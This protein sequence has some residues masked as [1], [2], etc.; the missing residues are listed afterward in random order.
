M[1]RL[2]AA[3]TRT[4]TSAVVVAPRL[5]RLGSGDSEEAEGSLEVGATVE[6]M[7]ETGML[8]TDPREGAVRAWLKA[9]QQLHLA[10]SLGMAPAPYTGPQ[11]GELKC[12]GSPI[13]QNA[14]VVFD[15]LPPGEGTFL[16]CTFWLADNLLERGDR[17]SMAASLE[18]ARWFHSRFTHWP[19]SRCCSASSMPHCSCSSAAAPVAS[20]RC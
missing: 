13:V 19:C 12:N 3:I 4:S 2:V 6:T 8:G 11:S 16:L 15:G 10:L 7:P 9:P 5:G 14:E 18:L 20:C 17:M 1:S